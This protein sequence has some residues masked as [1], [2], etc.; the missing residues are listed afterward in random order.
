MKLRQKILTFLLVLCLAGAVHGS[1]LVF[2]QS[3]DYQSTYGPSQL[4]PSTGTNSE[5]TDDFVVKGRID[6]AVVGGVIWGAVDFQGVYIRFYEFGPDN[7]P[8]ALQQEYFLPASDPNLVINSD[9]TVSA[10]LSP[11]FWATG[12][13]FVSVQPVSSDWYW[14]SSNSGKPS[15]QSFFFRN[16]SAGQ[17]VWQKGDNQSFFTPQADVAFSLYGAVTEPGIIDSLSASTLPRSGFLEIS[18]TNFGGSGQVLIGGLPAL[19]SSWTSTR[20]VAYVPESA[21]LATLEVQVVNAVGPSNTLFL[22]VT[23]RPVASGRVNWRFRMDGPY[24]MVRPAIGPDGT[25]YS[26]DAFAHLYALAPDGSLKWLANAAGDKGV[27]VA[28]DGTVYVASES[29]IKAF[30]PDGSAKWT[31]TQN[32]RAFI[33][34]G[35]AVGPDGNIYS[36]GVQGLGVFSLTPAGVLRWAVPEPYNRRIVDYAEI[37]FGPNGSV[38]QLYFGANSHTRALR[39]DGTSVFTLSSTFQPAIGPDGS[40]HSALAAF[41]P[42]GNLLWNFV[43]PYPYNS[44]T[45]A[46]VGSNGIHYFT[47]NLSELFALNAGGSVIWHVTLNNRMGGPIVDP[48]NSILVM[49][50]ADTLNY[51]GTIQAV[52]AANGRN[53]WLVSLP[54]EDPTVFNPSLG[55]YGYNQGVSTRAR[56]SPDGQTVYFM[57]YT[58]TG[59]NNT[60]RSFVYSINAA[61][62]SVPPTVGQL[63]RCTSISLSAKLQRNSTVSVV[64]N[65]TVKDENGASI[66]GAAVAVRWSLPDGTTQNQTTNTSST[67]VARFSTSGRRG[68]YMLTVSNITK[69]GYTFDRSN[70]VLSKTIMK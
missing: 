16:L 19:V 68:T 34:L 69:S 17:T 27:A 22:S 15:G 59:D 9:G 50:G 57:T 64:A 63:L 18:G 41:S 55:T 39:L 30:N 4:W 52:S 2:S 61:G 43:S 11:A 45:P 38:Q 36:V 44:F 70:S 33:C 47:Q 67:G 31:F 28:Q 1:E 5:V 10:N 35:I 12:R 3:S 23:E 7:A 20:I 56:F 13:H 8:G 65:V 51:P 46:D 49:G 62:S 60:S 58:A 48:S 32:P 26:V 53:L 29:F 54:V 40:V 37:V 66:S 6:R 14:W 25:I 21:P 24:S 42:G